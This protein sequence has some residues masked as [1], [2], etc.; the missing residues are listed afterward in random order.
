MAW[1][2]VPLKTGSYELTMEPKSPYLDG[3]L[4]VSLVFTIVTAAL[5]IFGYVRRRQTPAVKPI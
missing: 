5:I 1:M 3:A 4:I 2:A